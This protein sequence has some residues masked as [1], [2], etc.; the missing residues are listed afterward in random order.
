MALRIYKPARSYKLAEVFLQIEW[1]SHD[2]LLDIPKAKVFV[3]LRPAV[4]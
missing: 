1:L 2:D 3:F 4:Y